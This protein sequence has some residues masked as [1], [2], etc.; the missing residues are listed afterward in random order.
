MNNSL[1]SGIADFLKNYIPFSNLSIEDL[2]A[3]SLSINVLS[4]D[5]NETLFKI[6]DEI[7]DKFYV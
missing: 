7:H 5:K 3:I 4:V 2:R 6:G 1:A